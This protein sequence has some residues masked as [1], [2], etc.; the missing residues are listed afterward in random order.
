[1]ERLGVEVI[2]GREDDVLAR[3][4]MVASRLSLTDLV[5]ATA[6]NPAVDMDAPRRVLELRRR[7]RAD[8]VVEYGLPYGT[9]VEAVSAESLSPPQMTAGG[10]P[11]A[12]GK[13][14]REPPGRSTGRGWPLA[15]RQAGR[16]V[17]S[18]PPARHRSRRRPP[19]GRPRDAR[20][21]HQSAGAR[22]RSGSHACV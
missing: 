1:G 4:V 20:P 8:R 19:A 12:G 17:R 7:T 2:R 10:R 13:R 18:E 6:D 5:R 9:A 14:R 11:T 22:A 21:R 3:F 16:R 15:G